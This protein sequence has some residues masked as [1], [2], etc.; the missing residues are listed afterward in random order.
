MYSICVRSSYGRICASYFCIVGSA[1]TR[2]MA[3]TL[4]RWKTRYFCFSFIW[5]PSHA[6]GYFYFS[7]GL[8]GPWRIVQ[9]CGRT[10][11]N[12]ARWQELHRMCVIAARCHH[13]HLLRPWKVLFQLVASLMVIFSGQEEIRR[14]VVATVFFFS[15]YHLFFFSQTVLFS[16]AYTVCVKLK[17]DM[18]VCL[19]MSRKVVLNH[20]V[21]DRYQTLTT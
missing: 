14:F 10:R 5:P 2:L 20:Q 1:V 17:N 9:R 8:R 21:S 15:L 11:N 18:C 6:C 12:T 13:W 3:E 16:C 7:F 19:I 4:P